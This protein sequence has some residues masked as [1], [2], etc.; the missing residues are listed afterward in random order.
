M[1]TR[2]AS[3]LAL[4]AIVLLIFELGARTAFFMR[5][6]VKGADY[7]VSADALASAPW[8]ARYFEELQASS[9]AEWRPYVAWRSRPYAGEYINI[10]RR[11]VRRTW[12]RPGCSAD[13]R[14]PLVLMFGGSTMWGVGARDEFT[15]ASDVARTLASDRAPAVCVVNF[16]ELGYVTSQE[17]ILLLTELRAGV[18]P[19]LVVFYDGDNDA[20]AAFQEGIA[21][22]PQNE[23]HRRQEFNL[24]TRPATMLLL[25]VA[26]VVR[27]SG[28]YRAAESAGDHLVRG[29]DRLTAAKR[30]DDD[31]AKGVVDAYAYNVRIAETLGATYGFETR[32][33]WQPL[34]FDKPHATAYEASEAQ[35]NASFGQFWHAV[36]RAV[37]TDRDLSNDPRFSDLSDLFAQTRDP[38][39]VDFAHVSEQGSALVAARIAHDAI[40]ALDAPAR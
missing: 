24:A 30:A 27:H 40:A 29:R 35:R 8:R 15:I 36:E 2:F 32:F 9:Q 38:L 21:G 34:V 11:G 7:R 10:D 16:G 28:L 5:D 13:T 14:L 23:L 17:L 39:F 20:F 19:R 4:T 3:A 22:V 25:S 31:L 18:R 6:R 1:P 37:R 12:N 33:Y 26:D